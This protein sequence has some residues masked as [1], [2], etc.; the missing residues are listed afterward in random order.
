MP[1]DAQ[2]FERGV[3]EYWH[4]IGCRSTVVQKREHDFADLAAHFAGR[5]PP[6]F[7]R[8]ELMLIMEWKHTDARWRDRALRGLS[9]VNDRRLRGLTSRIAGQELDFLL[10]LLRGAI[11][12]V[13]IASVSAILTAARPD[14]F[15]VIDEFALRAIDFHYRPHWLRRGKDGKFVLD[16]KIYAAYVKFCREKA[17][18]LTA[19]SDQSWTPRQVEM[20]FWAIGK[21]LVPTHTCN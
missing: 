18:E 12:G 13:G 4:E 10:D 21:N 9:Q 11:R 15:C 14:Q 5:K 1:L 20:A 8:E 2:D 19:S 7:T 6:S 3:Q 16:E 17:S